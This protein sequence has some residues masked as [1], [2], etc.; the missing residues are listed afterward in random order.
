VEE[1]TYLDQQQLQPGRSRM[2][3]ITCHRFRHHSGVNCI[4]VLSVQLHHRLLAHGQ[5]LTHRWAPELA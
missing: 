5:H 1:W 2:A 4:Q 3:C